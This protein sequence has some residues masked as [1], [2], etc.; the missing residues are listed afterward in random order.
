MIHV[1]TQH[2]SHHKR[3]RARIPAGRLA[4]LTGREQQTQH[5]L[6][7]CAATLLNCKNWVTVW[8]KSV[9]CPVPCQHAIRLIPQQRDS[10]RPLIPCRP[11]AQNGTRVA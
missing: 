6:S 3:F 10:R 5:T 7:W 2:G 4:A 9:S 8:S 11:C 1:T